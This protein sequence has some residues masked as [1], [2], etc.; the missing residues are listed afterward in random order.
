MSVLSE[1]IGN[2][3]LSSA[4]IVQETLVYPAQRL[5]SAGTTISWPSHGSGNRVSFTAVK[6]RIVST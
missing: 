1:C 3:I 5:R 6:V 4:F 2:V